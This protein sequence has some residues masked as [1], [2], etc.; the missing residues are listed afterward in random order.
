MGSSVFATLALAWWGDRF[1]AR[2]DQDWGQWVWFGMGLAI[3]GFVWWLPVF[4]GLPLES[5][6]Y[7]V[8]MWFPTWVEG[9]NALNRKWW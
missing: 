2:R 5:R 4:L 3:V 7:Q 1:L 9:V 8:R 6:D